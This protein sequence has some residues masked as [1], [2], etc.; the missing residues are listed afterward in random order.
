[1]CH[2][3][4][5]NKVLLEVYVTHF[6]MTALGRLIHCSFMPLAARLLELLMPHCN[7]NDRDM[8]KHSATEQERKVSFTS[9]RKQ[10]DW[11]NAARCNT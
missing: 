8:S 1:M 6:H 2:I 3:L 9:T 11:F 10:S 7:C 5:Y 4:K